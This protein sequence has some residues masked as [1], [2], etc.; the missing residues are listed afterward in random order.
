MIDGAL[1]CGIWSGISLLKNSS[2]VCYKYELVAQFSSIDNRFVLFK[3]ANR[4]RI[5]FFGTIFLKVTS[6]PF[7]SQ[8][9]LSNFF[10]SQL[11]ESDAIPIFLQN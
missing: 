11:F 7:S 6:L 9:K 1:Q 4:N 5:F 10:Q 3:V 8:N 2:I